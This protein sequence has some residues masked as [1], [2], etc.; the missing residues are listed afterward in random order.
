MRT[1][2][3]ATTVIE[4]WLYDYKEG[5]SPRENVL[6]P[7]ELDILYASRIW[8]LIKLLSLHNHTHYS[9]AE[10]FLQEQETALLIKKFPT[11]DGTRFIIIKLRSSGM[12]RCVFWQTD[13]KVPEEICCLN[14]RGRRDELFPGS[15]GMLAPN[16]G[17]T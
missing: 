7:S 12:Y 16:N 5:I 8:F 3:V 11:S 6:L 15:S 10:A 17:T 2:F 13:T 4:F 9:L 1:E 14:V